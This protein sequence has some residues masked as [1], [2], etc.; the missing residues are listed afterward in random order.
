[1][2]RARSDLAPAFTRWRMPACYVTVGPLST[3]KSPLSSL[4]SRH[5]DVSSR[6]VRCRKQ[7]AWVPGAA[8]GRQYNLWQVGKAAHFEQ[9]WRQVHR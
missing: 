5:D 4:T 6:V 2:R 8:L 3:Y 1:M 9:F 7:V